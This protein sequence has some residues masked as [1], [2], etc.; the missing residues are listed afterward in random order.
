MLCQQRCYKT[1]LNRKQ[2][3]TPKLNEKK[4]IQPLNRFGQYFF[5]VVPDFGFTVTKF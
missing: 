1:S 4:K 5:G 3:M 2:Q